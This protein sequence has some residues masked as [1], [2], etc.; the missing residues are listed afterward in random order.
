LDRVLVWNCEGVLEKRLAILG[1]QKK[2]VEM[3][4]IIPG[5]TWKLK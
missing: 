3:R 1:I 4:E 2:I 5:C